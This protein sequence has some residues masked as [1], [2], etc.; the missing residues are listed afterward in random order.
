MEVHTRGEA[1][2]RSRFPDGFRIMQGKQEFVTYIEHSSLR[3]WYSEVPWRYESHCHSAVEIIM[4][5]KG[6]VIYQVEDATYRVQADEVLIVP[7]NC[8]HGLSMNAGSARYLLLFEPDSI[9]SMRDMRLVEELLQTPLYLSGQPELQEAVRSL[10]MQCINCYDRREFMWNT[11]CYSYLMQMYAR[12]GQSSLARNAQPRPEARRMEPEIVDSA[13]LYIDQ[14]FKRSISL[15]DVS[16][17]TGFSKYYF[18]RV[19]KQQ[20]GVS[21]SGYLRGKRVS[22]AEDLLIHTRQ[23]IQDIALSAGFGSIATFNRVFRESR[24]CTPSRYREIYGD[25]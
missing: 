15:E 13:R 23:S 3:I 19:F 22:M 10:L 6:E 7:P 25:M 9:F 1:M 8:V 5:V 20:M 16:A 24:G 18:S 17:F 2:S 21:F 4:P 12:L 11:L 14:N